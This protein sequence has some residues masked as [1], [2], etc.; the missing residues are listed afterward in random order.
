[1]ATSGQEY[2]WR[3]VPQRTPHVIKNCHQCRS[4]TEFVSSN[5]F[6]VNRNGARVDVWLIYRCQTCSST[7][8]CSV[9]RRVK[10]AAIPSALFQRYLRNDRDLA[11]KCAFDGQ[12]HRAN[13]VTY[14]QTVPSNLIGPDIDT[15]G[16]CLS[17]IITIELE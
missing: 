12:I 5:N 9:H 11:W 2:V 1:M 16:K 6:R 4:R 7:W 8:N 3:V 14:E 13:G 17:S 15:S 10:E